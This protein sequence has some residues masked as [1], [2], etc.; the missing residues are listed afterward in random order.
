MNCPTLSKRLLKAAELV[1]PC[2]VF[3]DVGTDHAYLPVYLIKKQVCKRAIASDL[4]KGPLESAERTAQNFGVLPLTD[5]RLGSGFETVSEGEAD[6]AVVAGMGGVLIS[7][8]IKTS[9]STVRQIKTL[10]LQPMTATYELRKFL[11]ENNFT[12]T[13]EFLVKE[14]TKLYHIMTVT[15]GAPQKQTEAELFMGIHL[16]NKEKEHYLEYVSRQVKKIKKQIEGL[17]KSKSPETVNILSEK[18]KLL[19]EIEN[20]IGEED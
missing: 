15:S 16:L 9:E 18:K 10:V 8:L 2:D 14:D 7:E 20:L 19:C 17:E 12:I 1:P 3:L 5:L 6:A 11:Y 13:D 4:R